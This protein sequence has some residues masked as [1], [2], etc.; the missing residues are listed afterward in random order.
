M[1]NNILIQVLG[2]IAE[3]ERETIKKRQAEGVKTTG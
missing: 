3:Q 2:T 1:V